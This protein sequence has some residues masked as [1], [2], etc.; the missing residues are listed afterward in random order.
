MRPRPGPEAL[1]AGAAALWI[2]LC[3]L[4]WLVLGAAPRGVAGW[5]GALVAALLPLGLLALAAGLARS[6]AALRA[7]VAALKAEVAALRAAPKAP[8]GAPPA[9]RPAAAARAAPP[10]RSVRPAEPARPPAPPPPASPAGAAAEPG[11][12]DLL[13]ALHFPEDADDAEGFAALRRV[14]R[15]RRAA[16]L[17]QAAQDVLTLLAEDAIYMDDLPGPAAPAAAWRAFAAGERGA[18]A[19]PL[20]DVGDPDAPA[21]VAERLSRDPVFR[22]AAHHFV[23]QFDAFLDRFAPGAGDAALDALGVTRTARAF[24][25]LAGADGILPRPEPLPA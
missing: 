7:E 11:I 6:A 1:A 24:G 25:L 16:R 19:A 13:R 12:A 20:A 10:F 21:R 2:A 14:L 8:E 18:A 9:R 4:F 5:V 15:S 17:V 3:L 23:R 22:D